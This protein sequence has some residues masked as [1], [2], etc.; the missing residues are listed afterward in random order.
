MT[1]YKSQSRYVSLTSLALLAIS[2]SAGV[3]EIFYFNILNFQ[4]YRVKY[5]RQLTIKMVI[6]SQDHTPHQQSI[7]NDIFIVIFQRQQT[8]TE[9]RF[10][11]VIRHSIKLFKSRLDS[12]WDAIR[13][14]Q[15]Q[16]PSVSQLLQWCV[17]VI[18]VFTQWHLLPLN[19][20]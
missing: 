17:A 18:E 20:K 12:Y 7:K 2:F 15:L 9:S 3:I 1:D 13:Y 8:L 10:N 19:I 5:I 4:N 14:G 16:R 6:E 11:N